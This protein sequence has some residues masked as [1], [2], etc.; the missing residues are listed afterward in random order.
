MLLPPLQKRGW[1]NHSTFPSYRATHSFLQNFVT[2]LWLKRMDKRLECRSCGARTHCS[3]TRPP[4]HRLQT[5]GAIFWDPNYKGKISVWDDLST[6]YMA[7]QL[8]GYD[9]PD[10]GQLYNLSDDQ[11]AAVKQKLLALK[12]NVRKI[13]STGGELTN[14]FEN[15]EIVAAMGWPLMTKSTP[16]SQFSDCRDHSQGKHDGMDRPFI[17]T[18]ASPNKELAYAF[19]EHDSRANAEESFRCDPLHSGQPVRRA[20][21]DRG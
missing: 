1:L 20:N 3:M 13:W 16:A 2:S 9:K 17:M 8:L 7:A 5:P 6:L 18:K 10:P 4:S 11:L 12:P 15:H 21:H 14:L 19:L